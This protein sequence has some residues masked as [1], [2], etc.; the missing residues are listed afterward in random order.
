VLR[1]ACC[2]LRGWVGM[3]TENKRVES[4]L[5][6]WSTAAHSRP[7]NW[8][9]AGWSL[10]RCMCPQPPG[11]AVIAHRSIA[12]PG[13]NQTNHKVEVEGGGGDAI[14][15]SPAHTQER[16]AMGS[17]PPPPHLNLIFLPSLLHPLSSTTIPNQ[18]LSKIVNPTRILRQLSKMSAPAFDPKNMIVRA[19]C[20]LI[21]FM[22][23]DR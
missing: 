3:G 10:L 13:M 18:P 2:V 23:R 19:T 15:K 12:V 1:V 11:D 6:R 5:A 20:Q 14:G 8:P 22:L 7:L 4:G 16:Q 21:P 17:N 9:W